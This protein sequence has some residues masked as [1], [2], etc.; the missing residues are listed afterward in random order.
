MNDVVS[1]GDGLLAGGTSGAEAA[2]WASSDGRTWTM[3][4]GVAA[5]DP[6]SAGAFEVAGLA[7]DGD[8]VVAVGSSTSGGDEDATS[9]R[10]EGS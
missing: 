10:S 8:A 4:Q 2:V 3:A 9:W 6:T 5:F 1:D 7:V